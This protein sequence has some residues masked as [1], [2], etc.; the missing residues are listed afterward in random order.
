MK[1]LFSDIRLENIDEKTEN[2][3]YTSKERPKVQVDDV[4][5]KGNIT[6]VS[7]TAHVMLP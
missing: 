5:Q 1:N 6:D 2:K 7:N 3:R 4:L